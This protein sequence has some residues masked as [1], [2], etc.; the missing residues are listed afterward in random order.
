M[1]FSLLPVG[2]GQ[3]RRRGRGLLLAGQSL[4]RQVLPPPIPDPQVSF[5]LFFFFF[6]V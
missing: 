1:Q 4:H 2:G 5:C 6:T 3:R